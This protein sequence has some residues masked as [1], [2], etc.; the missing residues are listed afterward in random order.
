MPASRSAEQFRSDLLS[1]GIL[2]DTGV[3]G[4]YHRSGTFERIA[5]GVEQRA[6][7]A[8]AD[9][10]A[11]LY[12]FPAIMPRTVFERTD[13]L[14]SFP[15][16]IGSI[17]TFVGDD[18]DHTALLQIA[19][20]GGDWTEKLTPAEVVM[21][22]A[23]CHPLYP[24]LTGRIAEGGVRVECQ[25]FVFRHEPSLDPARMQTFRQHE[26]VYIGEPDGA[27]AHRDL[28]LQRGLDVL[29][30]L[31]LEVEPVVANDPFFGRAGR[32]LAANQRDTTLKYEIVAP[33]TTDRLTAISSAN[34][35]QDHFGAPFGIETSSGSVAHTACIG[36]GL[37]RIT[38]ALLSRYGLD[39]DGW[40]AE[41]RNQLWP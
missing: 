23:A 10:H 4:L 24:S 1:A 19:E 18:N 5:R 37:E 7:A 21:C 35:H 14:K 13:Y 29:S 25:G 36:F 41:V 2:L 34:C 15:D 26:F 38:L 3:D 20:A 27:V 31:G 32:M 39:P 9:Q 40:P 30:G 16:L 28:W 6:S 22:S 33:I 8:G 17:D 12:Y 11:P